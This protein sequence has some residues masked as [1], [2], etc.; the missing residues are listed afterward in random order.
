MVVAEQTRLASVLEDWLS[1]Q[2][3]PVAHLTRVA[4]VSANTVW[5]IQQGTTTRPEIQTLRKIARGL[6]TDPKDGSFDQA[7]YDEALRDL[8]EAAGMG[9]ELDDVP[10]PTLESMI[11]SEGVKSPMKAAKLAAFL[12]KYPAMSADQR[13]LVDALIDHLGDE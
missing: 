13:R 11:R 12:R 2:R 9:G 8:A 6:A 3:V 5:L 10:P 4:K 7:V 1:R